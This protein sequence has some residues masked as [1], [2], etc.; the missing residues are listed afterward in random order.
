MDYK[1]MA[2]LTFSAGAAFLAGRA[3]LGTAF[4]TTGFFCRGTGEKR[5]VRPTFHLQFD[6]TA[7]IQIHP[8]GPRSRVPFAAEKSKIMS[9]F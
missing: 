2:Q 4:F 7:E 9:Y 8:A 5:K 3:F 1:C 6:S